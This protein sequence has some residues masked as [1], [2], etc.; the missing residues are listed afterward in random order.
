ML[1]TVATAMTEWIYRAHKHIGVV[2]TD[3][4]N[5]SMPVGG[6]NNKIFFPKIVNTIFYP[7][8]FQLTLYSIIKPFDVSEISNTCHLK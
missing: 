2:I 6:P 4:K 8:W 3:S 1:M 5:T 7:I